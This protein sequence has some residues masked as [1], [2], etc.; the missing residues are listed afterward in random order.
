MQILMPKRLE[1]GVSAIRR[2]LSMNPP[3]FSSN[4]WPNV[5]EKSTKIPDTFFEPNAHWYVQFRD[6]FEGLS[7]WTPN[8]AF[9]IDASMHKVFKKGASEIRRFLSMNPPVFFATFLAS[10][11]V[12]RPRCTPKTIPF[13]A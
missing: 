1:N 7:T 10:S 3:I 6:K 12:P 4:L 8:W 11:I 9:K 2:F 13:G 5:Q